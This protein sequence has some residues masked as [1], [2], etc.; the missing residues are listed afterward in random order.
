MKTVIS[1]ENAI[2]ILEG[3]V[4]QHTLAVKIMELAGSV[5]EQLFIDSGKLALALF[6]ISL[7][8]ASSEEEDEI[9]CAFTDTIE[10]GNTTNTEKAKVIYRKL[11]I[12]AR[13]E[14]LKEQ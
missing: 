14:N 3:V 10:Y 11:S 6:N 4:I 5:P 7:E 1:K 13:L 8:N 12:L 2:A 9:T